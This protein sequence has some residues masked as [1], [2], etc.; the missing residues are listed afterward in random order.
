VRGGRHGTMGDAGV[1]YSRQTWAV[2][3]VRVT[4]QACGWVVGG[5]HAAYMLTLIVESKGRIRG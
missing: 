1:P 4:G 3:V 5:K 2:V